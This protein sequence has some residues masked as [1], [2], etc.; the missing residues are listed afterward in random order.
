MIKV[1]FR[2]GEA[3]VFDRLEMRGIV[4]VYP[5]NVMVPVCPLTVNVEPVCKSL[6]LDAGAHALIPAGIKNLIL[7][8]LTEIKFVT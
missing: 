8:L 7:S 6:A 4:L 2:I 5:P 3:E 1:P